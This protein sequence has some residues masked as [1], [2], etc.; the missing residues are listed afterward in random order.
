L[1]WPLQLISSSALF[2]LCVTRSCALANASFPVLPPIA[3]A[4]PSR[5]GPSL[6]APC[7]RGRSAWWLSQRASSSQDRQR[8]RQHRRHRTQRQRQQRLCPHLGARPWPRLRPRLLARGWP[9]TRLDGLLAPRELQ[10]RP[11]CPGYLR[12]LLLLPVRRP[13]FPSQP[14]MALALALLPLHRTCRW[15]LRRRSGR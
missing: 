15:V 11:P 12:L 1:L 13:P 8:R 2:T 6:E 5:C 7:G 10:L 4:C 3:G 14:P 9:P